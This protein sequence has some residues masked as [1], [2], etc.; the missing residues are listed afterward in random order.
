MTIDSDAAAS[1]LIT[2]FALFINDIESL[3]AGYS[4]QGTENIKWIFPR[5]ICRQ[6]RAL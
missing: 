2:G 6:V 1:I 3:V 4:L 5:S